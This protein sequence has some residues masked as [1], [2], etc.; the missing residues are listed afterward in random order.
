MQVTAAVVT[1]ARADFVLSEL[2]LDEPQHDEVRVRLVATGVC[3]TDAVVRDQVIPTP[4]PIV[5]GHEGAGVVEAIG[6][7]VVGVQVG[8]HV[9]LSV[10]SCGQC[11]KCLTGDSAYCEDLF[12]RNFGGARPDGST[13]LRGS[14]TAVASTFFGQSSFATRANVAAR[15]VVVVNASLKELEVLGPLGCG[16]QTGAGAV[17][18][19]LRPRAGASL[20]VFGTGA[21]GTAAVMAAVVA[22]CTRIVAIDVVPSRLELAAELGA[23]DVINAREENT[24]ERLAAITGGRGLDYALDTTGAP[25]L[26]RTAVDALGIRGTVALVGAAAPGTEATFEI[27]ASLTKGW[28]FK[29]IV[30]GSSVPQTFI[31]ALVD[32]WRSGRFPFD[33]LVKAYPFSAINQAFADSE[34]GATIKPVVVFD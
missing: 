9:V 15:S 28:T 14:G 1:D 25:A 33:R 12:A 27:G 2:E 4:L 31:P 7:S 13:S 16:L 17:L 32:L 23:T 3:H 19:E 22:G 10:N 26:L 20:A 29:T 8:D 6:S 21:V 18:N 24:A 34:S 11:A 5:L 30:E